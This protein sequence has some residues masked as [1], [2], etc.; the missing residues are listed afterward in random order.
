MSNIVKGIAIGVAGILLVVFCVFCITPAGKAFFNS[1]AYDVQKADDVTNYNTLKEVEDT[2][3]ALI[4]SYESDKIVYEQYKDS[5]DKEEQTW[6]ANA[7]IRAN[8]TAM[9]YNNY[10]LKN[11]YVWKDAVPS[12]IKSEL[13]VIE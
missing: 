10:I 9:Q 8:K 3:R 13:P 5:E 6:A 11:S 7:K 1:W 4:V 12:D 2:C